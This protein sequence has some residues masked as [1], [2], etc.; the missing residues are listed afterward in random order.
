MA[1]NRPLVSRPLSEF[2]LLG[3]PERV[4]HFYAEVANGR[5]DLRVTEQQLDCSQVAGLPI[6]LCDLSSSQ[7]MGAEAAVV[8]PDVS[9]P[10][11]NDAAY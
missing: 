1:R 2:D 7:R 5:L 4:I 6:E 10:P 8:E 3:E 11:V 9:D